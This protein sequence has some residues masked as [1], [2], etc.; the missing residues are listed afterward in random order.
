MEQTGGATEEV[1]KDKGKGKRD[2][3]R[4]LFILAIVWGALVF[5]GLVLV[6]RYKLTPGATAQTPAS[7]PVESRVMRATDRPTLVM[8]AHP[9][10][11]CTRASLSELERLLA[12]AGPAKPRTHVVFLRWVT[13]ETETY[14]RAQAMPGVEVFVD[15]GGE[16]ARR[17]GAT[18]SGET[19]LYDAAGHLVF[20]GGITSARGHEG[21]SVGRSRILSFLQSTPEKTGLPSSPTFG[22]GLSDKDD[23]ERSALR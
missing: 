7:W 21:A 20:H 6:W 15:E 9:R 5:A 14:K 18:T 11:D 2:R 13:T 17:F 4:V 3:D 1:G 16:E 23:D 19:M 10:C 8:V 22:C 12:Q